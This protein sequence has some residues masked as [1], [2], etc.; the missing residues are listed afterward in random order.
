MSNIH[1]NIWRITRDTQPKRRVLHL[2]SRIYNKSHPSPKAYCF[3]K[4]DDRKPPLLVSKPCLTFLSSIC[5]S[6]TSNQVHSI[7]IY[8]QALLFHPQASTLHGG[9]PPSSHVILISHVTLCTHLDL[10]SKRISSSITPMIDS[11]WK[12]LP[13]W[14]MLPLTLGCEKVLFPF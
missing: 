11:V 1:Q 6:L 3:S 13:G 14:S 7:H 8:R 2:E 10:L 5:T 9:G 12:F 4:I